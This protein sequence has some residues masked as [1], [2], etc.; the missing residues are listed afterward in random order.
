MGVAGLLLLRL[1]SQLRRIRA[2][3]EELKE[4]ADRLEQRAKEA[5]AMLGERGAASEGL[6]SWDVKLPDM[7]KLF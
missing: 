4:T 7:F 3:L 2:E 5:E 1:V 6:K